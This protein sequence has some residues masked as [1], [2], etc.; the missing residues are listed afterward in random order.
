MAREKRD[1][2]S[3]LK[4]ELEFVEAGGYL[5]P[6]QAAWRP[7]FIFEDSPTCVN[8]RN[9]ERRLPCTQCAL[10]ELVPNGS[11]QEKFPCR[12]IPLDESGQTL[13]SLYRIGTEEETHTMVADWL[14]A[15]IHRLEQE[16]ASANRSATNSD[17]APLSSAHAH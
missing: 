9:F 5:T 1:L 13:H 4:R 15:T 17:P 12:H 2:L 10:I 8:H 11:K 3:I 6:Q 14:R 7:Q 16:R